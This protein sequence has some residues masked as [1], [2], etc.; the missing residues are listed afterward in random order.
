MNEAPAA[1]HALDAVVS[2]HRLALLV[3]EAKLMGK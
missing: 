1:C 3:V 2:V